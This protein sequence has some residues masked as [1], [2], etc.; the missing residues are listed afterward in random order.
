MFDEVFVISKHIQPV[1]QSE[2]D[3]LED[4]FGFKFPIG[5]TNFITRFGYG[6]YCGLFYIYT[7]LSILA[8]SLDERKT[9]RQ[10]YYE[11]VVD[12][13]Q[14]WIFEGS[15]R[16][17]SEKQLQK[18][19]LIGSSLDGDQLVFYPPKPDRIYILPRHSD[20]IVWVKSDFS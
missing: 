12:D 10:F 5:Y 19:I 15:E 13:K 20:K 6:E 2:V 7:P 16:V 4:H 14:H 18:S 3:K 9:W 17:L 8:R 1:P 11:S